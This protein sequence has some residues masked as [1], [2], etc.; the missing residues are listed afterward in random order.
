M[1]KYPYITY[2]ELHEGQLQYFILQKEFPHFQGIISSHPVNST[3][4]Q[5]TIPG[6]N[7]WLVFDYTLRGKMIPSYNDIQTEINTI[8]HNMAIWFLTERIQAEPKKFNK[9]KSVPSST[10]A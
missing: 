7:L 4:C 2:R 10:T 5:V 6:Y 9:W 3:L 8:M 1:T